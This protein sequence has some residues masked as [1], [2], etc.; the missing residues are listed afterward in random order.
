[1]NI[2]HTE[3]TTEEKNHWAYR[4]GREAGFEGNLCRRGLMAFGQSC[5]AARE[6]A[7]NTRLWLA[8]YDSV[9][10]QERQEAQK[11]SPAFF[12]LSTTGVRPLPRY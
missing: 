1:M 2:Q 12:G 5:A 10:D 4:E 11:A 6:D 7:N 8:G 9:T 3:L